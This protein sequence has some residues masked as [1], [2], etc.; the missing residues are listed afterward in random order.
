MSSYSGISSFFR[1]RTTAL[2]GN[3]KKPNPVI[4]S[5]IGGRS[6]LSGSGRTLNLLIML[7]R[8]RKIS[9][10]AN[11]SPRHDLH[12]IPNGITFL[13]GMNFPSLSM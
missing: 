5:S 10:L 3:G 11:F 9:I 2:K 8:K 1:G 7:A 13:E 6:W 12:P 4:P